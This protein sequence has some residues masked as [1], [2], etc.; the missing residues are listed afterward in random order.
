MHSIVLKPGKEKSLL[1][2]HPLVFSGAIARVE[3]EPAA[4]GTVRIIDGDGS[5]LAQAAFSPTSQIRARIWTFDAPTRIDKSFFTARI[6]AAI[7]RRP[8]ATARGGMRLIHG[9]SDGLPGLIVDRYADILVVQFLST[10]TKQW[11]DAIADALFVGTG[12][13]DLYERSDIGGAGEC[14]SRRAALPWC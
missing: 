10:C 7:K 3:G 2:R 11:R 5:F 8:A 4:G 6:N 12:P 14:G 1:R 9:E 13:A